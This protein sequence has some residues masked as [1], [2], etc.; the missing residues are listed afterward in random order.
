[1]P[2]TN[3]GIGR[4]RKNLIFSLLA[5]E[6]RRAI[7]PPHGTR[8]DYITHH[9]HRGSLTRKTLHDERH[10]IIR[11]PRRVTI[12]NGQFSHIDDFRRIYALLLWSRRNIRMQSNLRKSFPDV[13]N[14]RDM[15]SV[16][17]RDEQML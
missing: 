5:G 2:R 9:R 12:R 8:E 13:P 10:S 15:I 11:M 4:Q 16:R 7:V 6:F 3:K 14:R 1:M 17:V